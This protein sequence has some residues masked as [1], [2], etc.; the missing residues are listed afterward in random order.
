MWRAATKIPQSDLGDARLGFGARTLPS[1][2]H[3]EVPH[4]CCQSHE[5]T[6]GAFSRPLTEMMAMTSG[7]LISSQVIHLSLWCE[8]ELRH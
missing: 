2:W 1:M 6:I 7:T 4:T 3:A 8:F 5:Q